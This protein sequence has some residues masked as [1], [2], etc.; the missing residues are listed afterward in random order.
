[1]RPSNVSERVVAVPPTGS[2]SARRFGPARVA[3]GVLAVCALT[4]AL[5]ATT[6][7]RAVPAARP[8]SAARVLAPASSRPRSGWRS[9]RRAATCT[10]P[11]AATRACRSSTRPAPSSPPGGG[12][13]PTARRR[14][15]S[16]RAPARRASPA[17]APGQFSNPTSIAVDSSGGPSAGDV[18]VGDAGN[19]VVAE[20][21]HQ[22]Q[23]PLDDRR[24]HHPAGPVLARRGRGRRPERQ[25]VDRRWQH[26]QHHEFDAGGD[27]RPAVER[28]LS[29]RR[30]RSRSTGPTTPST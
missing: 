30:S 8:V 7:Q 5:G 3:S 28:H 1:M 19:N 9:I 11:T 13:L 22:R 15:R 25:P 16:A 29:A 23:L 14:A 27:V 18:Y 24:Q 26:R 6:A 17:R 4:L 20:V 12:E 21:R 10:S 2:S